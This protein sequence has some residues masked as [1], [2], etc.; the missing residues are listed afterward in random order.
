MKNVRKKLTKRVSTRVV[1]AVT[2]RSCEM[3]QSNT[4]KF[5][6][7]KHFVLVIKRDLVNLVKAFR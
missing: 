1:V 2:A 4:V 5:E 6:R 3:S 7:A